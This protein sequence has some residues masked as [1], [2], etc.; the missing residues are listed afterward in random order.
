MAE[1]RTAKK[2]RPPNEENDDGSLTIWLDDPFEH[3]KGEHHE[4]ITL[5]PATAGDLEAI[6]KEKGDVG[7]GIRLVCTLSGEFKATIRKM[8]ARDFTRVS[9]AAGELLGNES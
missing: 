4:T 3:P 6:D 9:E 2:K 7:K 1:T 5:K 8:S